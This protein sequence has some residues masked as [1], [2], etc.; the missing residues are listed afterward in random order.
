MGTAADRIE[1]PLPSGENVARTDGALIAGKPIAITV[2][3]SDR[4]GRMA[5][6]FRRAVHWIPA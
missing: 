5:D 6:D 2:P 4:G 1:R 3:P